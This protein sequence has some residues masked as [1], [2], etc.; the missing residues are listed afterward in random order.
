[1]ENIFNTAYRDAST[2]ANVTY[3]QTLTNPLVEVGRN[4]TARLQHTF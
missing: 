4:F 2:F 1:V 3:P